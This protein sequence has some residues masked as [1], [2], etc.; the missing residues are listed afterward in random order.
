MILMGKIKIE[1]EEHLK[2]GCNY[3]IMEKVGL[4][5]TMNQLVEQICKVAM[6]ISEMDDTSF[7]EEYENGKRTVISLLENSNKITNQ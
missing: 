5:N 1:N 3:E 6:Q 2:G 7:E 4:I